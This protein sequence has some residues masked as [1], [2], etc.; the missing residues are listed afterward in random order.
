M[1]AS[2]DAAHTGGHTPV[3]YQRVLHALKPKAGGRYIDGTIGAGGH[4]AGILEASSP[5]GQVLGLDLD[6]AALTIARDRL[7]SFSGRVHLRHGSY[8]NIAAFLAS[9]GWQ[10]IDGL[11]LDLGVSSMQLS[12]AARGF[13]FRLEGPLDMRFDP[14]Q[15]TTAADL[16]NNLSE[17]ELADLIARYGEEPR[18]RKVARAIVNA[19]P[20]TT[21]RELSEVVARA[22]GRGRKRIHPATRTFQALRITVNDEL[23]ALK[24][25]LSQVVDLLNPGGRIVVIAFHSLEDRQ[26]KRFFRQESLECICP[27][28]QPVCTCAHRARLRVITRRPIRPQEAEV[29]GNPRARSA[30]LRVAERL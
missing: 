14:T 11:L 1:G 7:A 18:A 21:T 25:G 8:V 9:L 2:I 27:P 13:S 24:A 16:V 12:D 6:P 23:E 26:V 20:F 29:Q 17:R 28:R 10:A 4:A 15:A 22:A 19:R 3:L 30:R 5:D